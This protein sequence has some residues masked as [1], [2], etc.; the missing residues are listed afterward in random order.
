VE[1]CALAGV[2]VIF[3]LSRVGIGS[4]VQKPMAVSV[5]GVLAARGAEELLSTML[6]VA[7]ASQPTAR[8]AQRSKS[9]G[10]SDCWAVL[11]SNF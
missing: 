5:L 4:C 9:G 7:A 11:Q 2:P 8:V 6:S 1:D 3:A 10:L